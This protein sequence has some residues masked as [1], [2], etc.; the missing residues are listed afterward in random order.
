MSASF[1]IVLSR[2]AGKSSVKIP[3]SKLMTEAMVSGFFRAFTS[4]SFTAFPILLC[5]SSVNI[6][7]IKTVRT[8]YRIMPNGIS[9]IVGAAPDSPNRLVAKGI[10]RMAKFPRNMSTVTV[11]AFARSCMI[12]GTV[13]IRT[14]TVKKIAATVKRINLGLKTVFK[15]QDSILSKIPQGIAT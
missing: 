4:A 12:R 2:T 7:K 13:T 8:L 11:A 15:S 5:L 14:A 9:V 1:A 10:P 6:T 3:S